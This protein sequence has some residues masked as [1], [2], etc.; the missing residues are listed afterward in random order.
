MPLPPLLLLLLLP[1][2]LRLIL[3]ADCH[4]V[5][6]GTMGEY[7]TPNIDIEEGFITINHNGRRLVTCFNT[8]NISNKRHVTQSTVAL[9]IEEGFIK[10][11]RGYRVCSSGY[12]A[13]DT[14]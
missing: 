5:K 12:A 3:Y 4:L 13:T 11:K 6:L 2:F 7:G 10:K 8:S 1:L 14:S 9:D